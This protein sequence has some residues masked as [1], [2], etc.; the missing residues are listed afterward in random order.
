MIM[1]VAP[2]RNASALKAT[3]VSRIAESAPAEPSE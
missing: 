3:R 1:V 2:H